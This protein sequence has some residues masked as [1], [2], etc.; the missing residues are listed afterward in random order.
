[1]TSAGDDKVF[2]TS[3]RNQQL[4]DRSGAVGVHSD[5]GSYQKWTITGLSGGTCNA[6]QAQYVMG[7]L[8]A[9][10][11]PSGYAKI[12]DESTCRAAASALGTGFARVDDKDH[13]PGGCIVQPGLEAYYNTNSG[14]A[15]PS[16]K[17]ICASSQPQADGWIF[18]FNG[19][20][21]VANNNYVP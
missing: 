16:L 12:N 1:M 3:H 6:F 18:K 21:R 15:H 13:V 9:V 10:G 8:N 20:P 4:E 11:C 19:C 5:K 14:R 2:I 7:E 17:P